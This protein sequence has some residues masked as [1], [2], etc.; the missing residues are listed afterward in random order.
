MIPITNISRGTIMK[1]TSENNSR[2]GIYVALLPLLLIVFL[3]IVGCGGPGGAEGESAGEHTEAAGEEH[4][5]E[6]AHEGE[7]GDEHDGEIRMTPV[8]LKDAG[9]EVEPVVKGP[10]HAVATAPGRVVPTQDGIAH[11]GTIIAG[12]VTKLYVTEG[13]HVGKGA[14]LAEIEAFDIG[15]LKGEYMSARGNAEQAASD[16]A[17]QEKLAGEG[18]GARRTLEEARAANGKAIAELRAAE[19]RLRAVG[20]DPVAV[21]SSGGFSSRIQLRSPINGVIARRS[22]VLGE[23]LGPEKDA[24]E[25]VNTNT[26]WIDAQVDPAL[27]AALSVG[28]TG[29][30]RDGDDHRH[31]GSIRF[32]SPT[33]DPDSRTV[34]VRVELSNPDTHL[35]PETFVSVEF[36]RT[37]S[38]YALAVPKGAIEQDG[39]GYYVYVE[40]EP[41]SFR[42]VPVRV[43]AES[44]D[45]RVV[46]A[47]LSEGDR[48]AVSGIFYLK[49]ARQKGE[50]QEHHH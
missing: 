18:I 14:A 46:S 47:G 45:R 22:V 42:R 12:R 36:E 49:S 2:I 48:I 32:I 20:I 33:V 30:V 44:G 4:P 41:G 43:D 28:S 19:A 10:V 21:G 40:H 31:A 3:G 8:M 37:V 50:L 34:T 38:G 1:G 26:V 29:F 9:I 25:I 17:R 23:Y 24:F 11:V 16:L 15:S 6:H 27:A 35:R 5:E 13:T 7:H 39:A